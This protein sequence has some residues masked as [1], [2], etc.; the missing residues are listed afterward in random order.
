MR[1]Y[2]FKIKKIGL[3]IGF[4][5]IGI[6]PAK[7]PSKSKNLET[8][9][10][11]DYAGTMQWMA[12]YKEKRMDI[13]NL[14]PGAKS[15]ICV[16]HN[17]YTPFN[18]SNKE[19]KGKISRYA[20]G[21]DYHK[22]MKMKLKTYLMEIKKFDPNLQGRL[23]VDTAPIMEKLW[24]EQAGL[25]W[26]GKHTN[27]ITKDY[28]SWVFLGEIILDKEL[29][30]DAPI[31]DFCGS[32]RSCLE[33]CPTKA[34]VEPYV[35]D[36]QKC[37][38]YLTIEYWDKP[39]DEGLQK[40]MDNWIFGCDICQNICPW[41]K[42]K[43][44]SSENRYWPLENTLEFDFDELQT[45]EENSY[46]KKFKKSPVLRPGWENFKRNIRAAKK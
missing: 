38:S 21:E 10:K 30:Y 1:K 20:C 15:V 9:L 12:T 4:D 8:W 37:I 36:A 14:F 32:C 43:K 5:K 41:N 13:Q 28:G 33:A 23:Y 22:I 35:L 34:I 7:Q 44:N 17:Y 25:G 2:T 31:K 3:D 24:A 27:L 16:A 19:E 46:K 18:H 26:Q 45:L 39:I 6:A 11:R 29:I 40:N 42:F